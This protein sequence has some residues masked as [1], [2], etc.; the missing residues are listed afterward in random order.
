MAVLFSIDTKASKD[1]A[2]K[3]LK[4]KRSAFPNAVRETL[5][6]AAKSVKQKTM[7]QTAK[8]AFAERSPNFFK[9]NSSVEF[10]RGYD[11]KTMQATVG[12]VS[13]KLKGGNNY[14]VKDLEQQEEGGSINNRSFMPLDGARMSGS[15]N[16]LV[17]KKNRLE[18]I[19]RVM[20]VRTSA[21]VNKKQAWIKTAI[22]AKK[23]N[24]NNALV[25][26][27][28]NSKGRRTLSRIN[29]IQSI[30]GKIVIN[31]TALYSYKKGNNVNPKGTGF[32][33][34]ASLDV[35][36]NMNQIFNIEA[37]KQI[38]RIKK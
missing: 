6:A 12:F 25:L 33:E 34:R 11:I 35:V 9:A 5:S 27:N 17:L 7:P 24:P 19:K 2:D 4:M 21:G 1:F 20:R 10:A 32:M 23:L 37:Q 28:E 36:P 16:R 18:N 22:T 29:S 38:N 15:R 13:Q 8:K 30:G 31:K 3:L 14:A 26:G